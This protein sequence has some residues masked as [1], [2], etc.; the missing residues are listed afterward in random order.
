MTT[1]DCTSAD[2]NS[3]LVREIL[4]ATQALKRKRGWRSMAAELIPM[5]GIEGFVQR[6]LAAAFNAKTDNPFLFS[7]EKTVPPRGRLDLVAYKRDESARADWWNIWELPHSGEW[8]KQVA[9]LSVAYGEITPVDCNSIAGSTVKYSNSPKKAADKVKADVDKLRRAAM[10][11]TENFPTKPRK[12]LFV[13]VLF[14][15]F[16]P[17]Q[18][19]PGL[20][21][22]PDIVKAVAKSRKQFCTK[23]TKYGILPRS[24]EFKWLLKGEPM[25]SDPRRQVYLR[26]LLLDVTEE[27]AYEGESRCG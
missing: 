22:V 20:S 21:N 14:Q 27:L 8:P 12:S 10:W 1:N 5:S 11:A 17:F 13:V 16:A 26:A 3:H 9:L 6:S 23:L 25:R 18:A 24:R 4:H 2:D 15:G 7:I 19:D